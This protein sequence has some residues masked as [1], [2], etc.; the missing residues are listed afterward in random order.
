[1]I[2]PN[3]PFTAAAQKA[4]VNVTLTE[5]NTRGS[6]MVCQKAAQ[7]IDAVRIGSPASGIRTIRHR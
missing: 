3:T 7:P 6:A 1:M 4:V 2:R 5:A